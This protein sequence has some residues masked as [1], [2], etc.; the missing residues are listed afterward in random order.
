MATIHV[1]DHICFA[2]RIFFLLSVGAWQLSARIVVHAQAA[3]SD[4]VSRSAAGQS[5]LAVTGTSAIPEVFR[6]H[7]VKCHGADG[8]GAQTRKFHAQIPDFTDA[9]WQARR[10]DARLVVSILDGKG[11]EMPPWHAKINERD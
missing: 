7:C 4:V 6:R 5:R 3:Y 11:Q 10:S 1:P 2:T 8:T 9:S